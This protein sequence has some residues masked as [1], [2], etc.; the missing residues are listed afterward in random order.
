MLS[1]GIHTTTKA[2]IVTITENITKIGNRMNE[3]SIVILLKN[4]QIAAFTNSKKTLSFFNF[5]RTRIINVI[6]VRLKNK[7]KLNT[8]S[9]PYCP[10]L[11]TS[12]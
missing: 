5:D 10:W 8:I 1:L 7:N 4:M 6:T 9:H 11:N 3:I 12:S 2:D